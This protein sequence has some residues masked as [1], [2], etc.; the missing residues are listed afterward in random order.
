MLNLRQQYGAQSESLAARLLKRRGYT[1]LETNYRTPLGEIDIIARDRD[2]IVF[3]EVK[4]RRSLGFGGPKWAVTP[5]K[6]RKISMVALYY[7]KTTRQSQV[8]ARF[9]VV[10]IRSLAEPPQVEIIRNAFDLLYG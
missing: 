5:K 1:I 8:K 7:L 3:V 2:T 10:A 6:Q 4:A 9:D